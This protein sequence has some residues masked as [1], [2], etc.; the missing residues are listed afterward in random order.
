MRLRH[1]EGGREYHKVRACKVGKGRLQDFSFYAKS[2]GDDV[3][4]DSDVFIF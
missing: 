1:T 3:K 4:L 2:R